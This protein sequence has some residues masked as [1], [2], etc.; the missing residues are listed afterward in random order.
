MH[1]GMPI[2]AVASPL[3]WLVVVLAGI[4]LA[5]IAA[6]IVINYGGIWFRAYMS[7]ANVSLLSLIGMSFR[8]V[9]TRTIVQ[10]KIMSVQAGIG[11]EALTGISTRR[12]GG[13]LPGRRQRAQSDQGD[14]RRPSRRH[15]PGF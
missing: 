13:P 1:C 5:A 7:S 10:G 4:V 6:A 12:L 8:R 14:H 11:K 9:D 15:R 2:L 3:P